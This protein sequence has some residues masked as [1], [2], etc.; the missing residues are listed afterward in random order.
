MC[1]AINM[2]NNHGIT[3]LDMIMT[4]KDIYVHNIIK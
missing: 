4:D 3:S 1:D 2:V